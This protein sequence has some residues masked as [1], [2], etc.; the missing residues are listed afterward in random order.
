M[1]LF[2]RALAKRIVLSLLHPGTV[3]REF[4]P[5]VL[6]R[7]TIHHG[8]SSDSDYYR[9]RALVL[10]GCSSLGLALL[11]SRDEWFPKV[12]AKTS[13]RDTNN[14]I[15]DVVERTAS[16][17]V[18]IEILNEKRLDFFSGTPIPQSNGSGFIVREDGLILTNAHVIMGKGVLVRVKLQDGTTYAG[19]IED[20]DMKGDL[21]TV[22]IKPDKKLPVLPLGSSS[23]LRPGEWVVAM[24][25]PLSLSN[26]ITAGVIS[27]VQRKS[28]ELKLFGKDI[29]YIQ[30]DAAI[31]FGNSG[32][33]LV[34][35]DGEVIGINA[36]KVAA[37]ISFAIPID[38]AK[39]FLRASEKR[40]VGGKVATSRNPRRY[41]GI[42]MLS[43]THQ[44][45]AEMRAR[46]RPIPPNI[47]GG[48]LLWRVVLG[49]PAHA[50]GLVP[51]DIV[52][53][54][55]GEKIEGASSVYKALE[56]S[57]VIHLKIFRNG[58]YTMV[59]VVPEIIV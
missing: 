48:V 42:T 1:S 22:R 12:E 41:I 7:R 3:S 20:V 28:A 44:I 4:R 55:N 46:N 51:G 35:L 34:N 21:A 32:G 26:T 37:G 47:D 25:S 57:N 5:A 54:L 49:S 31:T 10:F 8:G 6:A 59:K 19:T 11:A 29:D 16:A 18:N 27:T 24:G 39:E 40:R 43:L 53:E 13:K 23:D 50:A 15:A 17:V 56:T 38:Y 9:N 14:F 2:L 36:M 58:V 33:P 45:I 52:V 30:T